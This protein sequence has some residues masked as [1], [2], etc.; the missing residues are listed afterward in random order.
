MALIEQF[1]KHLPEDYDDWLSHI[2]QLDYLD[3][4]MLGNAFQ[5]AQDQGHLKKIPY[6]ENALQL[7][8]AMAQTLLSLNCDN[9]TLVAALLYPTFQYHH[10]KKEILLQ[11]FGKPIYKLISGAHNIDLIHTMQAQHSQKQVDNVR[12]MLLA[13]VDDIRMVLIKLAEQLSIL[14]Y[15][16]HCSDIQQQQIAHQIMQI[17]APLANR[18]G[19]G[20]IKWQ[21]E[22]LAF[23]YL[24]P[25]QYKHISKSLKMRRTDR[26]VFITQMMTELESLF[27]EAHIEKMEI[28]GRAK[29]I[30]SIHRKIQRKR[31]EFSEIYDASALRILV[32]SIKDCYTALGIIHGKWEPIAKE[33]DDYIAKPKANGYRSIHTAIIGPHDL[34]VEIQLRTFKMHEEAE[35]GVAAHWKYKEGNNQQSTYEDKIAWLREVMAWQREISGN[36]KQTALS[37][38]FNDRVYV[39]TPK[40]DIYDLPAGA[41]PLDFAYHIHT[42][43]GHRCKGAKVH[44][45]LVPLTQALQNGDKVEIM[46]TKVSAPSRDWINPNQ[47]YLTTQTALNKVRAWFRKENFAENFS[48]GEEIWEKAIR[49]KTIHKND[50]QKVVSK[51]NFKSMDD[52]IAAIGANHIGAATIINQIES[53]SKERDQIENTENHVIHKP[54]PSK[55]PSRS[56]FTIDGVGNLLTQIARCCKPIPGDPIIGYITRGHGI[57]IH[58]KN[59]RNVQQA[60]D[61]RSQRLIPVSWNHAQSQHYVIDVLIESMDRAGLVRDVTNELANEKASI[62]GLSTRVDKLNN[63]AFINCTLELNSQHDIDKLLATL[64]R[65]EGIVQVTRQ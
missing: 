49:H 46:T 63:V 31:T 1:S 7:G 34:N 26:E 29:H 3:H 51:L 13:M 30:Y 10:P 14:K 53:L 23:R 56:Q 11:Q 65:I 48:R 37:D 24:E 28:T 38:V 43:V 61:Y 59:C 39:F 8:V 45:K 2:S 41:T 12:R 42:E 25:E 50:I 55:N 33:F 16:R 22:D 32:P 15:L 36:E 5:F 58:H 9:E 54:K 60:M 27:K 62:L 52:L 21:M 44:G 17:Y 47:G 35:L 64:K 18:L 57:S 6:A 4:D 20:Q 40:G 19:I